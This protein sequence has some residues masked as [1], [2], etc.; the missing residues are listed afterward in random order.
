MLLSRYSFYDPHAPSVG[1]NSFSES[2]VGKPV[3]QS[4]KHDLSLNS[5]MPNIN[6]Y[7]Y[8]KYNFGVKILAIT[9]SVDPHH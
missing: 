8:S 1:Q 9:V 4:M 5:L 6:L 3:L 7:L 2:P